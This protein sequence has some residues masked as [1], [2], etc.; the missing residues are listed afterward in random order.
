MT[1]CRSIL[2]TLGLASTLWLAASVPSAAQAPAAAPPDF[3]KV[4]IQATELAPNFYRLEAVGPVLAGNVGVFT[5]ADGVF[6]VDAQFAQLTEKL[7]AAIKKVS[8]GRIRFLVNTHHHPDHTSGNTNFG[9][10][11]VTLL[12]RDELRA[13]LASGN[14]PTPAPGLHVLTYK[15]P[16]TVHMN[17]DDIQLIPVP[18][19]HTD[20]DTMIYFPKADVLMTGD[21]YRSIQYPN[22]DRNNGGS[23]KGVVD[24]LTAIL[25]LAKPTTK[26]VAGH[27][28]V[29][30]KTAIAANIELITTI[31]GRVSALIA[32]GKSQEDVIAAKP[33]ADLDAKVQQIGTTGD[34]FLGQVYAELKAGK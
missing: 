9:A 10:L 8:D 15:G 11:G 6:M 19:A 12:A 23:L 3:S 30:D 28:P 27:G 25:A 22:I 26:I 5:G 24:G 21:F 16:V 33:L 29:V 18:N 31:R 17:G 34:R 2:S 13:H 7:V 14:N 1:T 20:G 32:Q 4:D